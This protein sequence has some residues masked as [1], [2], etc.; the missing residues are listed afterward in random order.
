[1]TNMSTPIKIRKA[2]PEDAQGVRNAAMDRSRQGMLERGITEQELEQ[3]GFIL[4]PL[5]S[6]STTNANYKQR[7]MHSDHFWVALENSHIIAFCMGYRFDE[8]QNF[9]KEKND[10]DILEYFTHG[11]DAWNRDS[12]AV[13]LSQWVTLLSHKNR[14]IMQRAI[15]HFFDHARKSGVPYIVCEIAQFPLKNEA[16]TALAEKIGM[17][18][19]TTRTKTDPATGAGRITGVFMY[20]FF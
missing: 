17:K 2:K 13:Y 5:Q 18:M 16:S 20:D 11:T 19:V 9:I 7:I 8:M 10:D 3:N 12:R 14:G 1:M 6:E 4:Y 15:E